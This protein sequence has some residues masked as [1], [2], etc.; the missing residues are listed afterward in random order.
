MYSTLSQLSQRAEREM[1]RYRWTWPTEDKTA[2]ILS[3]PTSAPQRP[4]MQT[5]CKATRVCRTTWADPRLTFLLSAGLLTTS[6][7]PL[8]RIAQLVNTHLVVAPRDSRHGF[9]QRHCQEHRTPLH[10][11]QPHHQLW[12]PN[13]LNAPRPE[14]RWFF[15]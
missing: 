9:H 4:L 2:E 3:L 1:L 11:D 14:F 6:F 7:C 15:P 13:L 12:R 10:R 8:V 5:K